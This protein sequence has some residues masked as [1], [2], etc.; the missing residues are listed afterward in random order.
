MNAAVVWQHGLV[1]AGSADSGFTLKLDA[2]SSV[3]GDNDGFRPIELIA[4]GLAGCTA[5]DVLSILKK[6]RQDVT[7]FEVK[8]HAER[9]AEHP[10]VFT[11]IT[12]EYVV[13]GRQIAPAAVERAIE[14]SETKYC[15]VQAMLGRVV[16]I[17]HTYQIIEEASAPVT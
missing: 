1:F 6:K 7:G 2:D 4:L 14:L 15:P 5:M 8:V 9:A 12:V 11:K 13:R 16:P 10:R 17:Q 3:G